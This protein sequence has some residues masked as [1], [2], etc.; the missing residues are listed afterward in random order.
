M[1]RG[2]ETLS[3]I[4]TY[5]GAT[6]IGSG[7]TLALSG[8]GSIAD[9]S[10]VDN[11]GTITAAGTSTINVAVTNEGTIEATSGTL[12]IDSGSINNSG[13]LEADGATLL[14]D[15]V[16]NDRGAG[17]AAIIGGILDFASTMNVGEITFNNGGSGTA[18]GELV[19]GDP[20]G[21]YSATIN[22]FAGT[23][24]TLT[25]SDAIDLA[26]T[27][28]TSSPLSGSNLVVVLHNGGENITLTFDGFSGTLNIGSDGHGGTL[29]TDPPPQLPRAIQTQAAPSRSRM[30][31]PP[32]HRRRAIPL[33][34]PT[35]SA[36]S[37]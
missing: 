20:S 30:L 6:T 25:T 13:T 10:G 9:S 27:W 5:T 2:T 26:G 15:D 24:N 34:A 8:S 18:Y 32:T 4:N 12:T 22:G 3:G 23:G 11:A 29:I 36:P 16:V 19:L 21:G 33:K 31:T 14:I 37:R 7:E 1:A 35:I 17:N 28:T